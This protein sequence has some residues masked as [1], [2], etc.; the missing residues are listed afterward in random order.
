MIEH[1]VK[2]LS[3]CVGLRKIEDITARLAQET[4]GSS[5]P[6]IFALGFGGDHDGS[7]LQVLYHTSLHSAFRQEIHSHPKCHSAISMSNFTA[8]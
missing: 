6:S 4:G 3:V 2:L 5:A 1:H 7:F 8:L